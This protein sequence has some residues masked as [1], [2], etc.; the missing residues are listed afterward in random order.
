MSSCVAPSTTPGRW[1]HRWAVL[2]A[3]VTLPLLFLGAEVT[4]NKVGMVDPDWPTAPWL[5]WVK[6]WVEHGVG[7]LIEHGHRL[8][9]YTVGTCAIVLASWLWLAEP[10][11]WLCWLGT[12][13]L[14]GVCVQGVLG[15]LRVKLDALFGPNLAVIHGCFGQMVFALLVTLALCTSHRWSEPVET[16]PPEETSGLR[17]TA[18]M[19]VLLVFAQLVL[20]AIYRHRGFTVSLRGHMLVAFA[21]VATAAWL[22]KMVE[23]GDAGLK[24]SVRLLAVLVG[25]QVMLGVEAFFA[26]QAAPMLEEGQHWLWRRDLVRS[27]HVLV[28]SLVL[29]TAVVISL[30][31]RRRTAWA[32]SATPTAE[33]RLEGAA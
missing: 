17:H 20:G 30:E 1:L 16:A 26:R 5:L 27:A 6:S 10:R 31:A 9:G 12:A 32:A 18:L 28:G 33:G 3:L 25:V 14:A 15:G 23:T 4:T 22:L 21:V 7:F 8:A 19:L 2:T 29:A 13:A 11:R 24:G